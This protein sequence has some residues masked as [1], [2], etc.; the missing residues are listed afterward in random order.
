M[1]QKMKIGLEVTFPT[2]QNA[3]I[4]KYASVMKEYLVYDDVHWIFHKG[5]ASVIEF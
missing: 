2:Q 3:R 4:G 1:G 5:A